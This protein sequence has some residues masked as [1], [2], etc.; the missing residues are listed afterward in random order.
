MNGGQGT[1]EL[2]M[3]TYVF[4]KLNEQENSLNILLFL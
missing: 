4:Q 1:F 3:H 2:P